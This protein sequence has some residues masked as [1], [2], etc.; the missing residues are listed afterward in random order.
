MKTC[1]ICT[2]TPKATTRITLEGQGGNAE[3]QH[4]LTI[5]ICSEH[6][7]ELREYLDGKARIVRSEGE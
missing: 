4:P 3:P 5:V 7:A 6:V 1:P 2:K